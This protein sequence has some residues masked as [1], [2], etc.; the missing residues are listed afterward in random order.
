MSGRTILA[1][2]TLALGACATVAPPPTPP[3]ASAPAPLAADARAR[4]DAAFDA[5]W[6][7]VKDDLILAP[8]AEP[9]G[10]PPLRTRRRLATGARRFQDALALDPGWWQAWWA[11]G[12][13]YERLGRAADA[14]RCLDVAL[15]RAPDAARTAIARDAAASASL[16]GDHPA[17]IRHWE[18]AVRLD[19]DDPGLVTHLAAAHLEAG[20]TADAR[21]VLLDGI[22]RHGDDV[23][24]RRLLG[25][26]DVLE[27][28]DARGAA[29]VIRTR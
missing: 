5:G 10:P 15:A 28:E 7:L 25:R 20:E 2:A 14:V 24:L 18:T 19:P 4:R 12:K 22:R 8:L 9:A 3:A 27:Q 26:I 13:T 16:A 29:P 21:R 6:A 17:A 23:G 1:V 11:L